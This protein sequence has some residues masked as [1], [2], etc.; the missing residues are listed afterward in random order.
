M[1]HL[2]SCAAS[3]I[4]QSDRSIGLFLCLQSLASL[5]HPYNPKAQLKN[6]YPQHH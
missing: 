2:D 1:F 4:N 3:K 6:Q 5:I